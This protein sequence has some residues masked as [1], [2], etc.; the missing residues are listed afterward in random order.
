M[1]YGK[2]SK[3]H[4]YELKS[5]IYPS[6]KYEIF[7]IYPWSEMKNKLIS[8]LRGEKSM[9]CGLVHFTSQPFILDVGILGNLTCVP[10]VL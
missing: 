8:S 3:Y 7:L 10:T 4:K 1:K 2:W 6:E 9:V 5:R